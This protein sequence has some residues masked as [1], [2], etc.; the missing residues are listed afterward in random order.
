MEVFPNE[1]GYRVRILF[2]FSLRILIRLFH[3]AIVNCMEWDL[4]SVFYRTK[5][6]LKLK[7]CQLWV[8]KRVED[9][10][11]YWSRSVKHSQLPEVE[12]G[13][14]AGKKWILWTQLG[15]HG[16]VKEWINNE[17]YFWIS[18][19]VYIPLMAFP[20]FLNNPGRAPY[21]RY[22][23]AKQRLEVWQYPD[24]SGKTSTSA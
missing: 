24:N 3:V 10:D 22:F 23:I 15:W 8:R 4:K 18:Q 5:Y 21:V 12:E 20:S 13:I 11:L 9:R 1:L 6:I 14:A 7:T 19:N 16:W 17:R 2:L